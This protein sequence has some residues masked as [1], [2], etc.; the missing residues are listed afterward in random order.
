MTS[1]LACRIRLPKGFRQS[2][3]LTFHRRDAEQVSE[4]TDGRLLQKGLVWDGH[5]ACLSLRFSERSVAVQLVVD[6]CVDPARQQAMKNIAQRMLGLTQRVEVFEQAY[7]KHPLVGR[8]IRKNS[9]L[10]VPLT[11]TPFEALTWAITGQQISVSAAVSVRRNLIQ[12]IGLQ[13]SGGLWCFP[14]A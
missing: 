10:R 9:G 1:T 13:H 4:R 12:A 7:G 6:G 14:E 3:V 8:L 2:D 5:P 11:A